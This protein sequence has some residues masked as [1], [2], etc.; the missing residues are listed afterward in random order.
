MKNYHLFSFR[1]LTRPIW[2]P[3][4]EN[5]AGFILGSIIYSL[6]MLGLWA[7]DFGGGDP[8]VFL[9]ILGDT[10]DLPMWPA[11]KLIS[12]PIAYLIFPSFNFPLWVA[13]GGSIGI[14]LEKIIRRIAR[15]FLLHVPFFH[16]KDFTNP[17]TWKKLMHDLIFCMRNT[18][19]LCCVSFLFNIIFLIV[20]FMR[21]VSS[22]SWIFPVYFLAAAASGFL[23]GLIY[24]F[25]SDE[26]TA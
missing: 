21:S 13:V 11:D 2:Q 8:P 22:G 17:N 1:S 14:L 9:K 12:F 10:L 23:Y 19:L 18:I 3:V 15:P 24:F 16:K 6:Y 26:P 20:L 5:K 4:W 25:C 7:K